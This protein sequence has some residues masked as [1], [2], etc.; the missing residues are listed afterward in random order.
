LYIA[1]SG[2][3]NPS[4]AGINGKYTVIGQVTSG[5]ANVQKLQVTDVIRRVTVKAP[6]AASK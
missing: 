4:I 6:V 2:L 5:M 3:E 1:L